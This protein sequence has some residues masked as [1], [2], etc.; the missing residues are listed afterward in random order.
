MAISVDAPED[1]RKIVEA[2]DLSYP[3]LSDTDA[4]VIRA[5]GVE[6]PRGNPIDDSD[7][8]R[9]ATIIIDREGRVVWR[10]LPD[11]W[12]IRP[13]PAELLDVLESIP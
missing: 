1:S 13:R 11:N 7:I 10:H 9:P 12:R 5:F 8:A 6:H 4:S 2:Y 3:V